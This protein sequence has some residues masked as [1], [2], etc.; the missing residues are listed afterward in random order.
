MISLKRAMV[1]AGALL[2]S[3]GCATFDG[4][5]AINGYYQCGNAL[6][7]KTEVTKEQAKQYCQ[8][9]KLSYRG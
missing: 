5:I 8:T 9:P 3:Q 7:Y 4:P 6:V 2:M 1:A